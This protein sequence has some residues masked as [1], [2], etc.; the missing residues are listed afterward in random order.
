VFQ[1]GLSW[2]VIDA[3]WDDYV[4]AFDGFDAEKVAA[5]GE[6]DVARLMSTDRIVHSRAKIEGTIR[7]ARALIELE[8]EYG[9]VRAY[10]TSLPDYDAAREDAAKR[11][12]YMGDVSTFYWRFLTAAPVPSVEQWLKSQARDHPRIREM[13][14]AGENRRRA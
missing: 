5:Y 6:R 9:S 10:Q 13:V 4:R 7:N 12:S 8:R 2:S 14:A 11:F 3:R 1:A